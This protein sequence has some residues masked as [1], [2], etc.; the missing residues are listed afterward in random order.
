MDSFLGKG[1][2]NI[3]AFQRQRG[4]N[5]I[6]SVAMQRALNT[7]IEE[8]LFSVCF[9]SIHCWATNVSSMDPP[10]DYTNSPVVNQKSERENENGGVLESHLF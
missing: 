3:L 6:T 4:N 1:W 8:E 7:T 5:R 9:A 2:V 10:R